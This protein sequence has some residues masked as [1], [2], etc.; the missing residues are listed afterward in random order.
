MPIHPAE[1]TVSDFHATERIIG[2]LIVVGVASLLNWSV[3][4]SGEPGVLG[5]ILMGTMAIGGLWVVLGLV[6]LAVGPQWRHAK[7]SATAS[8]VDAT[9]RPADAPRSS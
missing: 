1:V 3:S 5:L 6:E 4:Q 2:G 7:A 8:P 9:N